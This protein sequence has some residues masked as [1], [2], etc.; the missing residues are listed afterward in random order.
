MQ[1]HMFSDSQNEI[2]LGYCANGLFPVQVRTGKIIAIFDYCQRLLPFVTQED[3]Q[4]SLSVWIFFSY[5]Q[6]FLYLMMLKLIEI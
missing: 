3:R 5:P 6:H 2:F 4:S 1:I